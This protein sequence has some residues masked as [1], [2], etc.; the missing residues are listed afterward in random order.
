MTTRQVGWTAGAILAAAYV[1]VLGTLSPPALQDYPAHLETAFTMADLLF[2]GGSRFGAMFSYH[3]LFVPYWLGDFVF[4][5]LVE[6]FGTQVGGASFLALVFLSLPCALLYYMRVTAVAVE[7]RAV[8]F[9]VSLYLATDWFFLMGFLSFRLGIA[10][11]IANFALATRLRNDWSTRVFVG[12]SL[13][14][15]LGYLLHLST[16]A[17]LLPAVGVSGLL[18]VWRRTS[19]LRT[20]VLLILPLAVLCAWHFGIAVGYTRPGDPSENPYTW[21][22]LYSK[23]AGLDFE[24]V[25]FRLRWDA[26]M[27]IG[28]ALCMLLLIGRVRIRDLGRSAFLEMLLLAVTFVAIYMI[29]PMGYSE[30]WYVDVRALA[31]ASL[32]VVLACTNLPLESFWA[33]VPG[34]A[35]ATTLATALVASNLFYLERHLARG[36]EWLAQYRAVIS[37]LPVGARVFPVMTRQRDGHIA[38]QRHAHAFIT[39]DREGLMPY[40]PDAGDREMRQRRS[41]PSTARRRKDLRGP[42][43]PRL[44]LDTAMSF[45]LAWRR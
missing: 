38:A 11:T 27:S 26:M 7:R 3:F 29:L 36:Q 22:T 13:A 33:R 1:F 43:L 31:L 20:E 45:R 37:V 24:F 4:A 12:Y 41:T 21:G 14:V 15:V 9:I 2:H 44:T 42:I 23:L 40:A 34:P 8:I 39:I 32:C 35:L 10:L 19:S 30:A 6:L 16:L 25:R 28:L 5:A 18:R 17:F